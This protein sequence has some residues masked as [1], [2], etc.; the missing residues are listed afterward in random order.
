[1]DIN[2]KIS[3]KYKRFLFILEKG[4]RPRIVWQVVIQRPKTLNV[5]DFLKRFVKCARLG[6]NKF[7]FHHPV[8]GINVRI[9]VLRFYIA[10]RDALVV[11]HL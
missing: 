8:F 11:K 7:K 10:V 3:K 9:K 2:V 4:G 6:I 5:I 1:M